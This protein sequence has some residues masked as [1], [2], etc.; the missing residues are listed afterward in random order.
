MGQGL[1]MVM[2][3]SLT[4]HGQGLMMVMLVSLTI[5]GS[6]PDDVHGGKFNNSWV[7]A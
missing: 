5:H 3:V 4:I 1:M 6:R 7:K 2:L